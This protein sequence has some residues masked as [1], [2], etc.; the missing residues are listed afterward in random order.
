ME[1]ISP[2]Q[3]DHSGVYGRRPRAF[4]ITKRVLGVDRAYACL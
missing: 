1:Q 3:L 2:D 4:A